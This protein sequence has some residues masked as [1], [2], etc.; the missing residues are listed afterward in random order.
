[1]YF[2][3]IHALQQYTFSSRYKV[4]YVDMNQNIFNDKCRDILIQNRLMKAFHFNEN[5][6]NGEF[7]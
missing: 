7:K 6:Q 2:V 5:I 3:R 1:M 4:T